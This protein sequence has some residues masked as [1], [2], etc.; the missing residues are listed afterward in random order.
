MLRSS[1][2]KGSAALIARLVRRRQWW[3]DNQNYEYYSR[4]AAPIAVSAVATLVA[5]Y[6]VAE[7]SIRKRQERHNK[8]QQDL[9]RLQGKQHRYNMSTTHSNS[10]SSA[11]ASVAHSSSLIMNRDMSTN[12]DMMLQ[13]SPFAAFSRQE[14]LHYLDQTAQPQN[15]LH[16]RYQISGNTTADS[17]IGV[18]S[19]GAVQHAVCRDT[20]Q[21]VAIKRL[22]K[23]STS[24]VAIQ[25]ELQ[26]L[27]AIREAGGH[28]NLTALREH[29][30][31]PHD[32]AYYLVMELVPGGELFDALCTTGPLCE[33][34]AARFVRQLASALQFLHALGLVHADVKPE[35]CILSEPNAAKASVKLVDFGCCQAAATSTSTSSN[36]KN[37]A[38]AAPSSPTRT[39]LGSGN[40]NNKESN[41]TNNTTN[42]TTNT[43]S[44]SSSSAENEQD[45]TAVTPAYCP[46]EVLAEMRKNQMQGDWDAKPTITAAYDMWSLGVILFVML[47]GAHP[48]D[49]EG[50]A[51]DEEIAHAILQARLLTQTPAWHKHITH[52]SPEVQDIL[53]RL[54][55]A[56]PAQ[57]YTAE[58]LLASPWVRGLTASSQKVAP[59]DKRM[60]TYKLHQTKVAA[61]FFKRMLQHTRT[62]HSMARTTRRGSGDLDQQSLLEAA[63]AQLDT[64]GRG[65]ISSKELHGDT[66]WLGADAK[67]SLPEATELLSQSH[68]KDHYFPAGHV[69]Y[70]EGDP[71]DVMYFIHSGTLKAESKD[72]YVKDKRAGDFF[73][74]DV[75]EDSDTNAY[76]FTVRCITP[77]HAIQILRKDYNK[78]IAQD[79]DLALLMKEQGRLRR[80]ERAKVL[81]AMEEKTK[82]INFTQGDILF[83]RGEEGDSLY[84][85]LEGDVDI[86][87]DGHKVRSLFKGE[88]TGEHAAYYGTKPYNVTAQC[89]SDACT[90]GVLAGK[91]LRKALAKNPV[92]KE[93]FHDIIMRR[94]FKKALCAHLRRPFPQT[95][96]EMKEAFEALVPSS[97]SSDENAPRELELERLKTL[98]KSFDPTYPDEDIVAMLNSL[99]L[100][101][102]QSLTW[103]EFK[104]IFTMTQES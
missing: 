74:E 56:D 94:D 47:M 27:I 22:P 32:D 28:P 31:A 8:L 33:A 23:E 67:L 20:Q 64:A 104:A 57:R 69:I 60:A 83:N 41:S 24:V 97:S 50:K 98:M 100:T 65:Y 43:S 90:L 58:E 79:E 73:G 6:S 59:S 87:V 80:R 68:M 37:K 35:N 85:L 44:A 3:R 96:Q 16:A 51:S 30:T 84:V 86:S 61:Q 14:T 92:L 7:P 76:A 81:L 48:F 21:A 88:M 26:A 89:M 70:R 52:L 99:D 9:Q 53:K 77:V 66:S 40:K 95:E 18:G 5:A 93:S 91:E 34:D 4:N 62:T 78:Y 55:H 72:G 42:T 39:W 54:M 75:L 10:E 12:C 102:S 11:V 38:T 19:F 15:A 63:F 82:S 17:I 1:S 36:N 103:S 71:G 2:T 29:F 13:A 49:L 25:R 46:P 45:R 101:S